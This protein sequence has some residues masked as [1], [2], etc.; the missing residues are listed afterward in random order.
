[1][2]KDFQVGPPQVTKQKKIM[3]ISGNPL[4]FRPQI[5]PQKCP[6]SSQSKISELT[7]K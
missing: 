5:N 6:K 4:N 2:F 1:M 3:F 7:R